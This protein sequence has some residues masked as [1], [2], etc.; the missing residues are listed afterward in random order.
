MPSRDLADKALPAAMEWRRRQQWSR[1]S[2]TPN[3]SVKKTSFCIMFVG[4]HD[5]K[6]LV[7]KIGVRQILGQK[8]RQLFIALA[9]NISL[10]EGAAASIDK[11]EHIKLAFL[12]CNSFACFA[13]F[14][15]R[16]LLNSRLA[17]RSLIRARTK[18]GAR[19]S[20]RSLFRD[21]RIPTKGRQCRGKCT[22]KN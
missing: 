15:T 8:G 12:T 17:K 13:N 11:K 21:S 14:S 22:M 19:S 3:T 4:I 9:L 2:L 20:S 6:M 7:G 18:K 5:E 16:R 1:F 10:A